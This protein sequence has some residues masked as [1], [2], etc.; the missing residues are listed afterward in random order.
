VLVDRPAIRRL[1]DPWSCYQ[2]IGGGAHKKEDTK[3][4]PQC[5]RSYAGIL[6]RQN[7]IVDLCQPS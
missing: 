3:V 5:L 1:S 7:A 4:F 2:G 6:G